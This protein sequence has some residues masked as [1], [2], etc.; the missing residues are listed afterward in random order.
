MYSQV[1]ISLLVG[2]MVPLIA[3]FMSANGVHYTMIILMF[4]VALLYKDRQS[5]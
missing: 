3:L 1:F 2:I 5:L 4:H